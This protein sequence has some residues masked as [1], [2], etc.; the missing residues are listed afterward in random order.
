MENHESITAKLCSF[1]RAHHSIHERN[2]IFDDYLAF[3]LMGIDEYREIRG[4]IASG[5]CEMC[6]HCGG[7]CP[8]RDEIAQT[9]QALA[10]IPLSREAFT[11]ESFLRF[12]RKHPQ[13]QY[14][15]CGA[16]MDSF[17]FRNDDP[18]VA[19]FEVDHPLTQQ[20]KKHRITDLG[21][22][23]QKN[24]H[25]VPVDFGRDRLDTSLLAAGYDP[26][27]PTFFTI[28]GVTYYLTGSVFEKTVEIMDAIS[29]EGSAVVLDYPERTAWNAA[30]PDRV[31][32]LMRMTDRF[33]ERMAQ[34]FSTEEMEGI[35][36]RHHFSVGVS[37]SPRA[38]QNAYF[39]NR[40]DGLKAYENIHLLYA[41]KRK[42]GVQESKANTREGE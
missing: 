22:T 36:G 19:V 41:E 33:G 37:L 34:G 29:C 24:A 8:Y 4:L 5:A 7:T 13:C 2:K 17:L 16:G 40:N 42:S 6:D 11:M 14:V 38:I 26:M 35:F 1:V 23:V 15:I 32:R 28:L 39:K 20:Y 3:D 21:W 12:R 18:N 10:P 25:F 27:V 9:V 31:R 30:M